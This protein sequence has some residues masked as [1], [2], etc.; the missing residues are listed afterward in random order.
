VE[1]RLEAGD[2]PGVVAVLAELAASAPHPA[3]TE[4]AGYVTTLAPCIPNY[5]ARRAAGERIGSGGIEKGV[6]VVVNR[7]LKGRRGMRWW[8]ERV[9][10]MIALRVALL[11]DAWDQL[12]PPALTA[13]KLPAF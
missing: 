11:N 8:R 10:G 3:L 1:E 5:A 6:D 4:F 7:R 13:Q 2:V 12:I 9:E